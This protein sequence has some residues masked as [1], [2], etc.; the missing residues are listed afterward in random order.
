MKEFI[1]K[2]FFKNK[3]V[4]V[5][6]ADESG[7]LRKHWAIPEK[8]NTVKLIGVQ[9]AV[10]LSKES[11]LLSGK[12]NVPTFIARY[13]NCE[14]VDLKDITNGLYGADEFRLILDNDMAEKVFKA[15]QNKKLS[16]EGKIIITV[17]IIVG[18]V[19]GYFLNTK[20]V[21]LQNLLTP[22][23]N[24]IVEVIEEVNNYERNSA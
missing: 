17:V 23:P 9:K 7:H 8:D 15:T 21:D 6:M 14:P 20:L 5:L 13:N 4:I 19:L 16:D 2:T 24:P 3:A 12:G 22:E 1:I 10:V 18:L 11:M